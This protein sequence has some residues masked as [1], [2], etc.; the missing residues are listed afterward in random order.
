MAGDPHIK[1]INQLDTIRARLTA[2]QVPAHA[3]P[4][5]DSWDSLVPRV[6]PRNARTGGDPQAGAPPSAARTTRQ[7][8]RVHAVPG[9]TKGPRILLHPGNHP[10]KLHLDFDETVLFI[11]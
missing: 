8:P 9:R 5:R 2:M 1:R 4:G 10:A 7:E 6:L 11:P 3:M